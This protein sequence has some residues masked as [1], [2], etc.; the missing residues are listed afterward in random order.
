ML[1][2]SP[3]RPLPY[4][5]LKVLACGPHPQQHPLHPR[6]QE[7]WKKYLLAHVFFCPD[8]FSTPL[9]PVSDWNGVIYLS[10]HP[11]IQLCSHSLLQLGAENH[12]RIWG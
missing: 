11:S 7:R 10:V 12:A 6:L 2:E 9:S 8:Y 3:P 5:F 1:A 4:V